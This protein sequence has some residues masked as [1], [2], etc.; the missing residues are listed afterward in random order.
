MYQ[1]T[2]S[3]I[4]MSRKQVAEYL[5]ICRTTLDRLN[6]PRIKI[7]RKVLFSKAAVDKWLQE[8]TTNHGGRHE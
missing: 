8:Q 5:H 4:L 6:L 3:D 2:N 1:H 7:R